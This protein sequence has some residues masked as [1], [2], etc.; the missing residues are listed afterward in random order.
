[1]RWTLAAWSQQLRVGALAFQ[2]LLEN[3]GRF[4]RANRHKTHRLGLACSSRPTRTRN[5]PAE[6][7]GQVEG[8]VLLVVAVV[9]GVREVEEQVVVGQAVDEVAREGEEPGV[10]VRAVA[11]VARAGLEAVARGAG[12]AEVARVGEVWEILEA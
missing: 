7:A 11:K 2:R 12:V 3:C 1:M 4:P 5:V 6:A 8:A 10:A 9:A